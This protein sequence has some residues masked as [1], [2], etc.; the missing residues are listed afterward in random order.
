MQVCKEEDSDQVGDGIW[1]HTLTTKLHPNSITLLP[2]YWRNK[3]MWNGVTCQLLHDY[4]IA[5]YNRL[6]AFQ[7]A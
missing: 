7:L 1:S 2:G 6:T 5:Q 4:L 3:Y